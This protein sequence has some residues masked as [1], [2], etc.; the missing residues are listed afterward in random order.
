M[1]ARETISRLISMVTLTAAIMVVA[2]VPPSSSSAEDNPARCGADRIAGAW[3]NNTSRNFSG[4]SNAVISF[5]ACGTMNYVASSNINN[6]LVPSL[7]GIGGAP[8]YGR[9]GGHGEWRSVHRALRAPV[10]ETFDNFDADYEGFTKEILYTDTGLK[11]GTF[12]V[13]FKFRIEQDVSGK[14]KL[15]G[16]FRFWIRK[17]TTLDGTPTGAFTGEA[18]IGF[19]NLKDGVLEGTRVIDDPLF[20]S[21]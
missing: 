19:E 1:T 17:Y 14:D 7:V 4:N 3:D 2:M 20:A 12:R 15:V 16:K 9:S 6:P 18:S 8:F 10:V 5:H 11:N 13:H 21:P